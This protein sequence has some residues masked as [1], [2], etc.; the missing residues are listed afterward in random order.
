[1]IFVVQPVSHVITA[2]LPSSFQLPTIPSPRLAFAAP[3]PDSVISKGYPAVSFTFHVPMKSL[4]ARLAKLVIATAKAAARTAVVT[5]LTVVAFLS[6]KGI[7]MVL[8]FRI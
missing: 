7:C 2:L 3:S 8:A 6:S 1:V 4:A 5:L